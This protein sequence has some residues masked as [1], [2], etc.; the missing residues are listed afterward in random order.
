MQYPVCLCAWATE[1]CISLWI[2]TQTT[3]QQVHFL[4]S[5]EVHCRVR[6]Q[7][8]GGDMK[9]GVTVKLHCQLS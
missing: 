3:G 7:G 4:H 5:P 1:G 6:T 2:T 9:I 8:S